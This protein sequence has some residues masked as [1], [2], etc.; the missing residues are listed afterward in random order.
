VRVAQGLRA[1]A[2]AHT[3]PPPPA[4][5][6]PFPLPPPAAVIKFFESQGK[7]FTINGDRPVAAVAADSVAAASGAVAAE[8]LA[9]NARLL[10][11][12]SA[13]DWATYEGMCDPALTCF[14]PEAAALGR[15]EGLE[16]H[17]HAFEGGARARAAAAARGEEV[18]WSAST[19]LAPAVTLL[20]G[21]AAL[22]TYVR[23][24]SRV[25]APPG[26]PVARVAET[27]VWRLSEQG[28]WRL[29]HLHRSPMPPL[30]SDGGAA[31]TAAAAAAAH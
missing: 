5:S 1:R 4:P 29:A 19:M 27:R 6:S 25:G 8:V 15:V 11:A 17:R 22:V 14:E 24:V 21:K 16:F 31:A 3:P 20:G 10:D 7:A 18:A 12:I 26:A 30:E 23:G 9:A 13:G 2:R 28:A